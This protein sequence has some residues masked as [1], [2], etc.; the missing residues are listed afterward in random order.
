[1]AAACRQF[2]TKEDRKFPSRAVPRKLNFV[3]QRVGDFCEAATSVERAY[4]VFAEA[5]RDGGGRRCVC[6]YGVVRLV[7]FDVRD[8]ARCVG[9]IRGMSD[10]R[11][12]P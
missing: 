9:V 6:E 11:R 7:V 3:I 4:R 1:L 12:K 8:F 5:V 2:G 10:V